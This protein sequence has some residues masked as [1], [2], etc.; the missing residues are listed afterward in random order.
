MGHVRKKLI[1]EMKLLLPAKVERSEH[2]L[3]LNGIPDGTCQL[4]AVE[5]CP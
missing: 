1:F 4:L 5:A 3:A 2:L